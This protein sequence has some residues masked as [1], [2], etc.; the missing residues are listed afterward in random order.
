MKK[1]VVFALLSLFVM[2]GAAQAE[3]LKLLTWK[4]YAPQKLIDAFEKETGIDVEVTFSNNE[5]M[6]AKLRATRGAGFDLAQPSQDRIASVQKK[7][8][9]YQPLDYSKID[10]SLFIPSMLEAVKKN[11][12][13]GSDS[14][15]VPFCWGTSGLIVNSD[16]AA[17]A[18]SFKALI[19]PKY[20]GRVS[21]R[22]KR[23]TLIAMGFALGYDPFAL[24]DDPKAYKEMLDKIADAMIE[25]KPVVKNYW[26][27]GDSLLESMRS[28]EVYVAMA[29]DA[30]GWKLHGDNKAIDFKAPKEGALGWIDT[31]TIPSKAKNVDAAYKWI[32][33]IMKPENAGYFSSQEKYATASQGALKYT[34]EAVAANFDRS[35]PQATIDN[36]KWYPPVPAKL[37]SMEGKILDKIKAAQ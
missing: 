11:T 19:D 5:E 25:A 31:F 10:S 29:W 6:I 3:T 30:G 21:Y 12:R 14:Y 2:T 33:F 35:F 17:E 28:E 15:A 8:N 27:N 37:E 32:N 20:K 26:A 36:I 22:L 16:K 23:P 18:D 9:L 4:G 34:D 7:F 1:I 24:Y 13:V